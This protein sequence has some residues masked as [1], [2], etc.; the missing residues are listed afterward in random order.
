[1]SLSVVVEQAGWNSTAA[2][3]LRHMQSLPPRFRAGVADREFVCDSDTGN[4]IIRL[5]RDGDLEFIWNGDGS[6]EQN[7]RYLFGYRG[8]P[9]FSSIRRA[10]AE[11]SERLHSAYLSKEEIVDTSDFSAEMQRLATKVA[12]VDEDEIV[13]PT[14]AQW[15]AVEVMLDA[16]GRGKG[17]WFLSLGEPLAIGRYD[18]MYF[19]QNV[20]CVA[21]SLPYPLDS[22]IPTYEIVRDEEDGVSMLGVQ[23]ALL[24]IDEP[25]PHVIDEMKALQ[26][27]SDEAKATLWDF[28]TKDKGWTRG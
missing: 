12:L 24:R 2:A 27:L 14:P 11:L 4:H 21:D 26:R 1:M 7:Y 9:S 13:E 3:P 19:G 16:R 6:A 28:A 25:R 23:P 22:L 20:A 15:L 10:F 5:G 8:W 18:G 17:D